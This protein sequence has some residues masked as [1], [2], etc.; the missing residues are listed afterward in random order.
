[1]AVVHD[2]RLVA[3]VVYAPGQELTVMEAK[4]FLQKDL[5]A[6]EVPA[7]FVTMD[8]LPLTPSGK[9]D[10]I[11]LPNPF[12]HGAVAERE[13]LEPETATEQVLADV[14]R[15]LL[16]V[17][18]VSVLD[19][20]FDLGGHSLLAMQVVARVEKRMGRRVDPRTLFFQD[21]R[22]VAGNVDQGPESGG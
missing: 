6:Y 1:V 22:Q 5:P 2:D 18:R 7:I 14:W 9:I 20:F 3:Y 10:R 21:L 17:E 19:N 15:E 11:R 4:D 8:A 12:S 13:Y 16:G